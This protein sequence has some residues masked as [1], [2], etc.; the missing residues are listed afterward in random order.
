MVAG[1]QCAG[2]IAAVNWPSGSPELN[3]LDYLTCNIL[4]KHA[5]S[6]HRTM[7]FLNADSV[8]ADAC[9]SNDE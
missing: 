2:L 8:K 3:P 7:E 5:C 6:K 9:V 4:E 1:D